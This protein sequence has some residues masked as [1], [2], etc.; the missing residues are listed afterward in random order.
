MASASSTNLGGQATSSNTFSYSKSSSS[1]PLAIGQLP[2]TVRSS[3]T[4]SSPAPASNGGSSGPTSIPSSATSSP[5]LATSLA[6]L[7]SSALSPSRINTAPSGIT[8]SSEGVIFGG[9]LFSLSKSIHGIDL[10][11]PT[12]KT[13]KIT[14]R[15]P[16]IFFA[17]LVALILRTHAVGGARSRGC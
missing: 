9:M 15:K 16:P 3:A 17:S 12:I 4:K 8:A 13:K 6:A 2:T 5:T 7:Q 14:S 10:T 11:I 1:P